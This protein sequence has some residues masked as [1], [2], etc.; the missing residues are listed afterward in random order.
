MGYGHDAFFMDVKK[1]LGDGMA[2]PIPAK[3]GPDFACEVVGRVHEKLVVWAL[4]LANGDHNLDVAVDNFGGLAIWRKSPGNK[5]RPVVAGP[6]KPPQLKTGGE[7]NRLLVILHGRVLEVY[8]NGQSACDP[9]ILEPEDVPTRLLLSTQGTNK[10]LHAEFQR[11]P[12]V[13]TRQAAVAAG[14]ARW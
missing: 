10:L 7:F 3:P 13:A 5:L 8:A 14:T 9:I 6:F 11:D 2:V 4:R 12:A 1:A